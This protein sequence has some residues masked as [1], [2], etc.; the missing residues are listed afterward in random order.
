MTGE[1]TLF[2]IFELYNGCGR[3]HCFL[4]KMFS[5]RHKDTQVMM[6]YCKPCYVENVEP[7]HV[8]PPFTPRYNSNSFWTIICPLRTSLTVFWDI[9]DRL[10]NNILNN[11]SGFLSS[12]Q[13]VFTT[14][15][16]RPHF[17]PTICWDCNRVVPRLYS[18][19]QD[20]FGPHT[21]RAVSCNFCFWYWM[22]DEHYN[23]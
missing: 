16:V 14:T 1:N 6:N 18:Q 13:H 8:S 3:G 17:T 15:I 20:I 2:F 22:L 7:D 9:D 5:G 12:K 4:R 10:D 11:T 21:L 23:H 19:Q